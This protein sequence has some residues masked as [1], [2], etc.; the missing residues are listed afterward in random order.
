VYSARVSASGRSAGRSSGLTSAAIVVALHAALI[1]ALLQFDSVRTA[2]IA[3]APV[4]V[5]LIPPP[6][7]KPEVPPKPPPPKPQV[8]HKPRPAPQPPVITA[9]PEAPSTVTA[10]P[11]PPAPVSLPPVE[12]PVAAAPAPVSAPDPAPAPATPP[13]FNAAYL[14]N[15]PPTYPTESRRMGE[16]GRVVLR[17]FVNER[18]LPEEVQVRTSS[19]FSRLDESAQHTVRQWKFVPAKRGDTA[20]GAWVLVPIS[21]NLRS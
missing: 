5:T 4:M 9:K 17:V 8:R 13:R 6:R 15:P 11:P 21:F 19:G 18:G 1:A 16:E 2:I 14:N 7:E 10:L 12:V 20:V 3:A